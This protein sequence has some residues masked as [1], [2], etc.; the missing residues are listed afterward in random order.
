MTEAEWL[1]SNEPEAMLRHLGDNGRDRKLRL[2]T[3][4][5]CRRIMFLVTDERS[6]RAVEIAERLVDGLVSKEGVERA[7]DDARQ[8]ANDAAAAFEEQDQWDQEEWNA[9]AAAECAADAALQTIHWRYVEYASAPHDDSVIFLG[10]DAADAIKYSGSQEDLI[11]E[12]RAQ[13]VL[14]RDIF[15]NP[16]RPVEANPAWLSW[17]G[18]AIPRM[19]EAIY[20]ERAFDRL[21]ILADALEEAGCTDAAILEHC[22]GPG[23]H[24]RGCWVVDLL[25]GKQ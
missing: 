11:A 2:F 18:R 5:C 13:A 12:R 10:K 21:P 17:N 22:R 16:F 20:E 1:A 23:P 4:A 9:N 6:R 19:A 8:A 24:V 3:C 14:L 7:W 15:G 25:L